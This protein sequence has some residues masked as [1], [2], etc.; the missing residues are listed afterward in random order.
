MATIKILEEFCKSCG[1]CVHSCP[2]G[3][4]SIGRHLNGQGY[5][6][7]VFDESK[8]CSG[9]GNCTVVCPDAAIELYVV[10]KA[11]AP[12]R[13]AAVKSQKRS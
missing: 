11:E 1:L 6:P 3:A 9:C 10:R 5:N 13:L 2:R 12:A 7:V 4:L 8:Q